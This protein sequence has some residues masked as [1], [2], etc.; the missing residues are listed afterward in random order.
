MILTARMAS[1]RTAFASTSTGALEMGGSGCVSLMCEWC[2]L[3]A[4]RAFASD[5]LRFHDLAN[6][7]QWVADILAYVSV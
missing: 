2:Q 6:C 4:G 5:R 1:Q 7:P 3:V